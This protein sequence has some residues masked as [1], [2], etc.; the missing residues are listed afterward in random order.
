MLFH[1]VPD[2]LCLTIAVKTAKSINQSIS[3]YF[4]QCAHRT[5]SKKGKKRKKCIIR[6]TMPYN[7]W[8]LWKTPVVVPKAVGWIYLL[9]LYI[10]KTVKDRNMITVEAHMHST[11][12]LCDCIATPTHAFLR[13]MSSF[14]SLE[15]LKLESSNLFTQFPQNLHA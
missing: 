7:I 9:S 15:W 14:I 4:R 6:Q 5:S 8:G 3:L 10:S 1:M 2:S 12:M 11:G 13:F